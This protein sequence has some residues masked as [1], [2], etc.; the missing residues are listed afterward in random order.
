MSVRTPVVTTIAVFIKRSRT[1][2][3]AIGVLVFWF[4]VVVASALAEEPVVI[5]DEII[6][7]MVCWNTN[8]GVVCYER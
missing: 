4:A 1:P 7:A 8:Q 6:P 3:I 5:E 2:M